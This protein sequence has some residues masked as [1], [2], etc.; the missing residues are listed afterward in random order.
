M[1][2]LWRIESVAEVGLRIAASVMPLQAVDSQ[3]PYE[4]S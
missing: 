3:L 2:R 4:R 1:T